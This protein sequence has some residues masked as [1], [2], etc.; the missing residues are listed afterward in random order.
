MAGLQKPTIT[1]HVS[2][3]SPLTYNYGGGGASKPPSAS[4]T[5]ITGSQRSASQTSSGGGG[6]SSAALIGLYQS[7]VATLTVLVN[8]LKH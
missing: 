2:G 1:I 3:G 8:A 5:N 6:G 7:L 4:A